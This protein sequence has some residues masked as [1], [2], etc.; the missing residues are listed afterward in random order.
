MIA[1]ALAIYTNLQ[2]KDRQG[3]LSQ[4]QQP[5]SPPPAIESSVDSKSTSDI[6]LVRRIKKLPNEKDTH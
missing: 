4:S 2:T 3:F 5:S 1:S 6:P